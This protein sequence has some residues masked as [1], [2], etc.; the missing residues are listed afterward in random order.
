M[1]DRVTVRVEEILVSALDRFRA[2]H[3]TEF[4]S[5]QDLLRHI[6]ADWLIARA[7][8]SGTPTGL[9]EGHEP[10]LMPEDSL[11]S[12]NSTGLRS[13]SVECRRRGL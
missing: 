4:R 6:I 5:R 2:D 12:S 11:P 13:P 9:Q 10:P 8:L 3:E 7:Y 1:S